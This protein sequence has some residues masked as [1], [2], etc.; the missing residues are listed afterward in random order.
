MNFKLLLVTFSLF[1]LGSAM[2]N[3]KAALGE[4]TID[5]TQAAP[6]A[7]PSPAPTMKDQTVGQVPAQPQGVAPQ[8]TMKDEMGVQKENGTGNPTATG[9]PSATGTAKF[10][11]PIMGGGHCGVSW[12]A[13]MA[14]LGQFHTY[15]PSMFMG[16]LHGMFPQPYPYQHY[17][18]AQPT[19]PYWNNFFSGIGSA[20]IGLN[21]HLGGNYFH[22]HA[23]RVSHSRIGFGF[24]FGFG[25]GGGGSW[26]GFPPHRGCGHGRMCIQN[27]RTR[28]RVR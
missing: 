4:V 18:W 2:A 23:H 3:D 8:F 27:T 9:N 28:V 20:H 13:P 15:R 22:P 11:G 25:F 26:S 5:Q 12:C 1:S 14:P 7:A 6:Q 10:H 17:G 19:L 16:G 24:G 21:Y